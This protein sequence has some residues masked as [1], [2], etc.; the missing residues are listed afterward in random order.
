MIVENV[1]ISNVTTLVHG[2]G[3]AFPIENP[4][5]CINSGITCPLKQ[6]QTY[7]Y[8]QNLPIK[9]YYPPVNNF[10]FNLNKLN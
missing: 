1:E 2:N 10:S 5:A 9:I 4:D 8:I 7:E 3:I 6:N